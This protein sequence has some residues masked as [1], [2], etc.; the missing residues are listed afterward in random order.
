[1]NKL[2][3]GCVYLVEQ[4]DSEY[5]CA[6]SFD[7]E[8]FK[9][10]VY[11]AIQVF[12][13]KCL[14]EERIA[15][16]D[17]ELGGFRVV[18]SQI[19][20]S[21]TIEQV[22]EQDYLTKDDQHVSM[23]ETKLPRYVF[24]YQETGGTAE[25]I[26]DGKTSLKTY[27]LAMQ[28][29][30]SQDC[31]HLRVHYSCEAFS[32]QLAR[33]LGERYMLLLREMLADQTRTVNELEIVSV[34]EQQHLLFEVNRTH[35]QYPLDQAI[36]REFERQ[37][38]K[39]PF[40]IAVSDDYESLTYQQLEQKSNQLANYLI[41]ERG[42]AAQELVG[43]C[44]ERSVHMMV[45]LLGILKAGGAYVPLAPTDSEQRLA[46]IVQD[47][48]I[49]TII[50]SSRHLDT[51]ERLLWA[52]REVQVCLSL[53]E[54]HHA[55]DLA[56]QSHD[57]MDEQLWNFVNQKASNEI[58]AG[59][60]VSSY[61]G[62]SFSKEEMEQ[63]ANNVLIKL[64]PY[65]HHS[66]RVLEI[67]CASG[68]TMYKVAPHVGLYVGTDLSESAIAANR[69]RTEREGLSHIR[70]QTLA[71]HEIDQLSEEPFDIVI[72]NSVVQLFPHHRY[73]LEVLKKSVALCK[74]DGI[75]FIGDVMDL[76]TKAQLEESLLRYKAVHP[77]A[78]TKTNWSNE[79][80]LPKVFWEELS[81]EIPA[82][83]ETQCEKKIGTLKNELTSFRY[84]VLMK[85]NHTEGLP[86]N[87]SNRK[88][89]QDAKTLD[90]YSADR[91]NIDVSPEGLAYC[92]YTSGSTGIPKGVLIS[93]RSVMNRLLWMQS[94]YPL[95][96]QDVILQKTAITFDVSV[97][98]LFWWSISGA[99]LHFLRPGG[100]KN[101]ET[102]WQTV[103]KERIS[104]MHFVPGMLT[105]F[106]EHAR[107]QEATPLLKSLRYVFSSGEALHYSQAEAFH[108]LL[109][110]TFLARLINLYGPTEATVDVTC[111]DCVADGLREPIPIGKPIA[112]IRLY[113]L[114]SDLKLVPD[115]M[116]GE[117]FIG[118]EGVAKGYLN[119]PEL[120]AERFLSH[121]YIPRETIYRTG[122]KVRRLPD[123][124]IQY[125][126]RID[127][128]MKWRGYRIEPGEIESIL[129]KIPGILETVVQLQPIDQGSEVLVAYFTANASLEETVI[130]HF[131]GSRLA[132][133]MMPTH[134]IEVDQMSRTMSGKIDRKQL[135]NKWTPSSISKETP[136]IA[137]EHERQM[138]SIW[139][140]VCGFE[141][142]SPTANF[143]TLGG[144]SLQALHLLSAVNDHFGVRLSL[145]DFFSNPSIQ[146]VAEAV[147]RH[148]SPKASDCLPS[149]Q[150]DEENRYEPF[151]LND[152]QQAYYVGRMSDF[153]IGSIATHV[154]VELE[155]TEYDHNR[156]LT[157]MHRLIERHD[158][159]RCVMTE[160]GMQRILPALDRFNIP[161]E[162]IRELDA[163]EKG[164]VL[165]QKRSRLSS[166]VFSPM[167]IP[168][169]DAQVT[170]LEGSKAIVHLYYDGLI[171]DGWSQSMVTKQLEAFYREPNQWVEPIDISYRDY[172]CAVSGHKKSA[173]YNKAKQYWLEKLPELPGPPELPLK[174]Q[175][176]H[177]IAPTPI[178]LTRTILQKDWEQ[179]Q[180][181]AA[182]FGVSPQL[183]LFAAFAHVMGHWSWQQQFLL[184]AAQFNRLE[185]H[186]QVNELAGEFASVWP[187]GF[188]LRE[189]KPFVE[190]VREIESIF[191]RDMDHR[192][193]SGVEVLRELSRQRGETLR[194][195]APVVFTSLLHL[196]ADGKE[197]TG[198]SFESVYW[199]SQTS[200][201]WI[202]AIVSSRNGELHL[203]WDCVEELFEPDVLNRMLDAYGNMIQK[204]ASDAS[205]WKSEYW[206]L[207]AKQELS[208]M[209][210]ANETDK[211]WPNRSLLETLVDNCAH[212]AKKPAILTSS[213]QLSYEELFSKAKMIAVLL[214]ESGVK[215]GDYVV[216]WM[217]K[218]WEQIVGMIAT[219]ACGAAYIPVPADWPQA[220]LAHVLKES[221]ARV[222]LT[223]SWLASSVA[224]Y[225]CPL[226]NV[227]ARA[228]HEGMRQ[229]QDRL[230][231]I[232]WEELP[233][234]QK[235]S[236]V[237]FVLFTS[238]STGVPKGV[239]LEL[240]G[241]MNVLHHL[242][243]SNQVNASDRTL[244]L[245]QLHHDFSVYDTLGM[246]TAG[247]T[248]VLPDHDKTRD[249]GHW[250]ALLE[251]HSVTIWNSVPAFMEM[252]TMYMQESVHQVLPS[253]RLFMA[254]GDWVGLGLPADLRRFAP[255][256][257]FISIGGPTETTFMNISYPV[258]HIDPGW[259]SIPYG[260]PIANARYYIFNDRLEQVPI[261]VTGMMYCEGVGVAKGYL[262]EPERTDR[263]FILHPV[264][265][266]RLYR[267]GD[268][269][270]YLPDGNIEFMGR[271][272][273][274][275]KLR[276]QRIELG[277]IE[278]ALCQ[279]RGIQK[280]VV[281]VWESQQTL[282]AYY[283]AEAVMEPSQLQA[284]LKEKLPLAMVPTFFIR[285]QHIPLTANGK[286][287]RKNLPIQEVEAG[288]DKTDNTNEDCSHVLAQ[289]KSVFANVLGV[290]HVQDTDDLFKLGGNSLLAIRIAQ[291]IEKTIGIPVPLSALFTGTSIAGLA[292][293]LETDVDS[294]DLD[295]I[296]PVR[297]SFESSE[298][299]GKEIAAP[300]T[301]AQEGIWLAEQLRTSDHYL[302][303]ASMQLI[304]P[305]SKDLFQ[306]ALQAVLE[307]Q[308]VLR[309]RILL[310][311]NEAVQVVKP[312]ETVEL[313]WID[314]RY[315]PDRKETLKKLQAEFAATPIFADDRKLYR[316]RMI[317]F[318][319]QSHLLQFGFHHVIA[320]EASFGI[321][322]ADLMRA[323]SYYT[324]EKEDRLDSLPLE[325]TDYS[326]W[327]RRTERTARYQQDVDY[328][329]KRLDRYPARLSLPYRSD[330][331]DDLGKGAYYWLNLE[332]VH[333]HR[334]KQVCQENGISLFSGW[335]SVFSVLMLRVGGQLDMVIGT[336]VST[337][338]WEQIEGVMGMFV[339]RLPF[340]LI[341]DPDWDFVQLL[342]HTHSI[343]TEA[344][345]HRRLPF[346]K[347]AKEM[348]ADPS[349]VRLPLQ[350][351]FNFIDSDRV[352]QNAGP[353][354]CKSWEYLKSN[355]AHHLG[356]FIEREDG[357][358]RVAFSYKEALFAEESITHM[359]E[360]FKRLLENI[361]HDP[362][363]PLLESKTVQAKKEKNSEEVEMFHFQ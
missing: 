240:P 216:I 299:A 251:Q 95:G 146:G 262:N 360:A 16:Q 238:G 310:R 300:L 132:P 56:S 237:A 119:R 334:F 72:I 330:T 313:E 8:Q 212:Y 232:H 124:H 153:E 105:V 283:V 44:M 29:I 352:E 11:R 252:F 129:K 215:E 353:L 65:L 3:I 18:P 276:G 292:K 305:L 150:P 58:E 158:A 128:Q 343:V 64:E 156:M 49:R 268:L 363:C 2:Q 354:V 302:L 348:K 228:S 183:S 118:G 314:L 317:V 281:T 111:Y 243:H 326:I 134:F 311:G 127:D 227:D 345:T 77:D 123:G 120:T 272:D 217:E 341:L 194:S 161:L 91:P 93:H 94:A 350:V 259:K 293:M 249:P 214:R 356:L 201:V 187:F 162:D 174:K 254:G 5:L 193:F 274:Q 286:V 273:T 13:V 190:E 339:N 28:L 250:L 59:G 85:V 206:E 244:A 145:A 40:E 219:L 61:S 312:A 131:L 329:K 60:W 62:E 336:P 223:Q 331:G 270:R 140:E 42:I 90:S 220:R 7:P 114:D 84:D 320:D 191:W 14:E 112:N 245:T 33:T 130:R 164:T 236:G 287:D 294:S 221:A 17:D 332:P 144:H 73:L 209:D 242:N 246:L 308:G 327:L 235:Q 284:Y 226:L 335:L 149:I 357:H 304:G 198:R 37:V 45:A 275:V 175:P 315:D 213:L 362:H 67:G 207:T 21:K 15:F 74:D 291:R 188:D 38:E 10:I 136:V 126:G 25:S 83:K 109:G 342:S 32:E 101:P 180:E 113:I 309:T 86:A 340:R 30:R 319:E 349:F 26:D 35:V 303:P 289:I 122:D 43:I 285:L 324:G 361:L 277:E 27:D 248:I 108:S 138:A 260:K 57:L 205:A 133:Y 68:L 298:A 55:Q 87:R 257:R 52:T 163:E 358:M 96:L 271:A 278:H 344:L 66:C 154:Y 182:S 171:L 172:V 53:N 280:A 202:D 82:V 218:G 261:G 76:E 347:V 253:L 279:F 75:L 70:L 266:K 47:A 116:T 185:I 200:Q 155:C 79:L 160:E 224:S 307:K 288:F 69:V 137:D 6:E 208:V 99:R 159:L 318:E 106:L 104:T 328:W 31:L 46:S 199:M 192:L 267:T 103:A 1:M 210:L 233:G 157:A 222:I 176:H 147:K 306:N 135:A 297:E 34:E 100:E 92:L 234:Y 282:A 78:R 48:N 12:A 322:V 141:N 22:I 264:S 247:G 117:L 142:I 346:E 115:G 295:V 41:A 121:P 98:E 50:T 258:D 107:Q 301:Y 4:V 102:I 239:M 39:R 169:F 80:F 168:L 325:Y 173:A 241:L 88:Q 152:L 36:H 256:A 20:R 165:Q 195:P 197:E 355:V 230:A 359:A 51:A 125:L 225:G 229:Q 139:R 263:S 9:R 189:R 316:F 167:Q 71:A 296:G 338:S 81:G 148:I 63:Y 110:K 19:D 211:S 290:R 203:I 204:L 89:V 255:T 265:G 151:P 186:S 351:G 179:F 177:I 196:G 166:R 178:Q 337:R 333:V 54:S 269:G 24:F 323:Y 143:Y 231:L 184:S 170:L 181:N 23:D 97:W 321:F